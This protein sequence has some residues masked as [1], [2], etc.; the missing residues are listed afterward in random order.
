MLPLTV[1]MN[2]P[3]LHQGDLFRAMASIE[4]IEMEVIFARGLP[5]QRRRLGWRADLQG[6]RHRL[7]RQGVRVV[8]AMRVGWS[9]RRR[10]HIVSGI[11]GEPS[12]TAALLVLAA[13]GSR[14]V[15]YSEAPEPNLSR[16][17]IRRA[18]RTFFGKLLGPRA[19]GALSISNMAVE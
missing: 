7:L 13:T 18:L 1:W 16:P 5:D 17:F 12:F 15:I 4:G 10:F 2:Y 8:D 3:S 14:Y 11:W 19:T 6:Y 9:Q